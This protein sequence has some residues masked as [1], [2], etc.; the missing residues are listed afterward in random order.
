MPMV[1]W[2]EELPINSEFIHNKS[3]YKSAFPFFTEDKKYVQY[4]VPELGFKYY[5]MKMRFGRN[6][7][8]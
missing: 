8:I 5:C 4:L 3:Y 7:A 1:N 2:C 6:R